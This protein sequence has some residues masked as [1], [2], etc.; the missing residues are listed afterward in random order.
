MD[1][2]ERCEQLEAEGR[3]ICHMEVG[4]PASGAPSKVIEA[5]K[6]A[7]NSDKLGYT[8][9]KGIKPLRE[10][11]ATS[12]KT[13]YGI[14]IPSERV[15]VTTGSSA[16]F[17]FAFLGCFDQDDNIG[18][19]SSGYPCYRNLMKAL[20]LNYISIPVNKEYKVTSK[21]LK[22]EIIRRKENNLKPLKGLIL[23]NPSNPT[24]AMLDKQ[25]VSD[26]CKTCDDNGICFISDEIYHGISYG[27]TEHSAL[28]FSDQA[29]IINSFSKYYS[30]T[31]WRLGWMVVPTEMINVMNKLSQN[32][33]INA[34]TLSQIS[35]IEAFNCEEEL[36]SHVARYSKNRAIVLSTLESL[37]LLSGASPS[38][39]AFYV[40][41]DLKHAGVDDAPKLCKRILEEAGVALTPGVDFED[42]ESGLGLQRVRFS[43]SRSTDEVEEGMKRF[44]TWWL[45]NM[46][47]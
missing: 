18:L 3:T 31:G 39:G 43:Y 29:L 21:E 32:M 34:P 23:S 2:V 25:E 9:A 27:K 22:E 8:N 36:Q 37:D 40:Y 26:L 14:D 45:Q 10:A 44:K 15:I 19:C 20:G 12:Y 30:M 13:K 17:M 16:A 24:G 7:L 1:V 11:I 46:A 4:Q 5:A 28:E 42:A 6:T 41:V 35:A 38:D 33:Y 47:K